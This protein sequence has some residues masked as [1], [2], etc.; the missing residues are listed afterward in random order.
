M[1]FLL[2]KL[3]HGLIINHQGQTIN[4]RGPNEGSDPLD[5]YKNGFQTDNANAAAGYGI[6]EITDKQADAF[7]DWRK[8]VTCKPDGKGGYGD[9][10][11]PDQSFPA[12]TNGS[13]EGPFKSV[14]EAR[15]EAKVLT[16][17]VTTGFEGIDPKT[18]KA[19]AAA[20]LEADEDAGKKK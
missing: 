7:V 10:L 20:G 17:A 13:I 4:L 19:M 1:P 11:P 15:A 8:S 6:T 3:P 5:P 12:V 2:C 16:D 14:D 18:D 9:K